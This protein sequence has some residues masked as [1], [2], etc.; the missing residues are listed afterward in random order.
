MVP[1][2]RDIWRI[3]RALQTPAWAF[4]RYLPIPQERPDAFKLEPAGPA[5]RAVLAK[6]PSRRRKT[7]APC[8][9]LMRT[10][11][12]DHR[13]GLG[14]LRPQV[15]RAFPSDLIDGI[16]CVPNDGTCTCR[17]WTLADVDLAEETARVEQRQ[18]EAIEYHAI[19]ARWNARV[20]G[21]LEGDRPN[22]FTFCQFLLDAYEHR[23]SGAGD[24]AGVAA[25]SG[26]SRAPDGMRHHNDREVAAAPDSPES[27]PTGEEA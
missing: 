4:L 20:E 18:A 9:F 1:S 8:I 6:Q 16:L 7:P 17:F 23:E 12:G 14:G 2:G 13:C 27:A 19:V 24:S 11:T 3:A 21:G 10:R 5:Y 15:C 22:F 25:P 26:G